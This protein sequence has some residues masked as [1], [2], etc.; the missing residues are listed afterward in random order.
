[1]PLNKRFC[2][3]Y[4]HI[5]T[6]RLAAEKRNNDNPEEP[7][8][9]VWTNDARQFTIVLQGPTHMRNMKGKGW[10]PLQREKQ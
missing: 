6:A 3:I 10:F 7:H 9:E 8:C 4:D 1:M 5:E 2:R